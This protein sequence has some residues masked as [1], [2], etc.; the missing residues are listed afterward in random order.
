MF[1]ISILKNLLKRLCSQ[2]SNHLE[3][4]SI[5]NYVGKI[6]LLNTAKVRQLAIK[7][8]P[9]TD[10]FM[11]AIFFSLFGQNVLSIIK[12]SILIVVIN[13]LLTVLVIFV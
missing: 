12:N 10:I 13:Y 1:C 8:N 2:A 5:S 11:N 7:M 4:I 6:L 9:A 3:T